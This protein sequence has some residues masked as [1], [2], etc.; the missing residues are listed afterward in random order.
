MPKE[1]III[2][3]LQYLQ[4]QLGGQAESVNI[5]KDLSLDISFPKYDELVKEMYY[6]DLIINPKRQMRTYSKPDYDFITISDN[7][8]EYYEKN[9]MEDI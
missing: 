8:K 9:Q 4:S 6:S 2:K 7:G 5:I 3:I 1:T